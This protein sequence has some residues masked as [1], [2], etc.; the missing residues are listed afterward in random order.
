MSHQLPNTVQL[1]TMYIVHR[2]YSVQ[3]LIMPLI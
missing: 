2:N 3:I 1:L